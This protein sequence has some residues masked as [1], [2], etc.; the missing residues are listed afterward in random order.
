MK[1]TLACA[2][3]SLLFTSHLAGA[4]PQAGMIAVGG[5]AS[6]SARHRDSFEDDTRLA[7]APTVGYY[8]DEHSSI[9]LTATFEYFGQFD[10]KA[11]SISP[12]WRR[13]LPMTDR[14]GMYGVISPSIGVSESENGSSGRYKSLA[15]GISGGIGG[16]WFPT[17]RVSLDL[18]LADLS[19]F[20]GR[21]Y[22]NDSLTFKS[23]RTAFNLQ[24]TN[25]ALTLNYHFGGQ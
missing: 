2:V 18:K 9:G 21:A 23:N 15:A 22:E 4:Q 25:L 14:L 8:Y 6:G 16:Y 24:T 12:Y 11:F 17:E 1:N 20:H 19:Y 5:A 7:L 3:L 10:S 13:N